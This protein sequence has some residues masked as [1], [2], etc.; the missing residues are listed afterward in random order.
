MW[1]E[2]IAGADRE[3]QVSAQ[4]HFIFLFF[5]GPSQNASLLDLG[6][7]FP[8]KQTNKQYVDTHSLVCSWPLRTSAADLCSRNRCLSLRGGGEAAL[9]AEPELRVDVDLCAVRTST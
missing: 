2:S 3:I 6:L 1:N 9:G 4:G 8:N 5:S 7:F